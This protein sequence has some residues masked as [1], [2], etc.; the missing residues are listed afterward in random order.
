[1]PD[2]G[3]R[4]L[5]FIYQILCLEFYLQIGGH[6]PPQPLSASHPFRSPLPSSEGARDAN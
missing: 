5:N 6:L 2:T 3:G 1:M 4:D